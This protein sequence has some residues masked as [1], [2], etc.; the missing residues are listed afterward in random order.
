MNDQNLGQPTQPGVAPMA[1]PGADPA[2][3]DMS[4]PAV[5]TPPVEPMVTPA[6][7]DAPVMPEPVVPTPA[8]SM[9]SEPVMPTAEPAAVTT[10]ETVVTDTPMAP[11]VPNQ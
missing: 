5:S 10:T 6:A 9:P 4:T 7:S 11:V 2:P 3:M 1:T 8:Q